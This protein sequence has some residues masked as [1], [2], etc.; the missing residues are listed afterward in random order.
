MGLDDCNYT[1]FQK[2]WQVKVGKKKN[3]CTEFQLE[4]LC[5]MQSL[6]MWSAHDKSDEKNNSKCI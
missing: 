5:F 6:A 2:S 1:Q 3:A 4:P